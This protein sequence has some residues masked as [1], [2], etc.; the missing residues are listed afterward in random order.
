MKYE[1]TQY[2]RRAVIALAIEGLLTVFIFSKDIRLE[3][4]H[5]GTC[6]TGSQESPT[7]YYKIDGSLSDEFIDN[8][9]RQ[10]VRSTQ[11]IV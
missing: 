10:L 7:S 5:N 2:G 4:D 3:W 11:E 9:K 1:R 6:E 8:E